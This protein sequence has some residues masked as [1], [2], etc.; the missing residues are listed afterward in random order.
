MRR[1][2][3]KYWPHQVKIDKEL[4]PIKWCEQNLPGKDRWRLAGPNIWYF[5]NSK[6][7]TMFRIRW[8]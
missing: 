2:N 6:D 4:E 5:A 7:A 3:K 8:S 1:L